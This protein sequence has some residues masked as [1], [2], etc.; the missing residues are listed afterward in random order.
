MP[1]KGLESLPD[2]QEKPQSEKFRELALKLEC[3][4]D[5]AN[6]EDRVRRVATA[7]KPVPQEPGDD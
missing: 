1:E 4:D 2:E 3:D 5:E 7:P 6:F